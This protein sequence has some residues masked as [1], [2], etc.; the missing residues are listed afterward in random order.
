MKR[1]R[2]F[3][4]IELL[5][6]I[7]IIAVLIAILLPSL[8]S[9]KE[10]TKRAVCLANLKGQGSMF[11]IY[12][13]GDRQGSLIGVS[14]PYGGA[15]VGGNWL[16]DES[17][18]WGDAMLGLN[19]TNGTKANDVTNESRSRKLFFCPSNALYANPDT[20]WNVANGSN[21]RALGYQYLNSRG[22]GTVINVTATGNFS[23][24]VQANYGRVGTLL[25]YQTTIYAPQ[26]SQQEIAIDAIVVNT[27]PAIGNPLPSNTDFSQPTVYG[28]TADLIQ[29]DATSH[30][31][32]TRAAGA[33]ELMLDSHAEW[34]PMQYSGGNVMAIP[35]GTGGSGFG[36]PYFCFPDP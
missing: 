24:T 10:T 5:V 22:N 21:T 3:T 2:G 29:N 7:A 19:I 8:A 11:A 30:L 6:V 14:P 33:N 34:K 36:T 1:S 9:A 23:P 35:V 32:G 18:A 17:I 27:A 28:P 26:A 13:A 25:S 12:A 31:K 20:A 15:G 16:H 4:L